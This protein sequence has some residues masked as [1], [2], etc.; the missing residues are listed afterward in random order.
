MLC[1]QFAG[2]GD[3][4]QKV[5][6][7]DDSKGRVAKNKVIGGVGRN[8]LGQDQRILLADHQAAFYFCHALR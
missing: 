7:A 6:A 4:R 2:T 5:T 8:F 3:E 1:M